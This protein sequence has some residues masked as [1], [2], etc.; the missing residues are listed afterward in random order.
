[1]EVNI[2]TGEVRVLRIV[3]QHDVGRVINPLTTTSQ[4]E[5]GVLQGMGLALMEDRLVDPPTGRVVTPN[6]E[7]YKIPTALDLPDIDVTPVDIIDPLSNNLGVKG[8][9]EPPI[10]PPAPAIANAIYNATGLRI[11]D[12]PI[13]PKAILDALR[14]A[15]PLASVNKEAAQ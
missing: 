3:G 6:L 10:I 15:T 4:M 1:V 2:E 5:G 14:E 12:L 8:V 9:G 13:T 11:R 7:D